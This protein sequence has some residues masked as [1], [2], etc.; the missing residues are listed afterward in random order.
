MIPGYD[1]DDGYIMVEQDLVEA[2]RLVTRHIHH[3]A[4]QKHIAAP[5]P[6]DEIVRP[7][8][9]ATK[10]Q[11]EVKG[12]SEEEEDL[13]T[14]GQLLTRRPP[15]ALVAATPI[16]RTPI[17]G[18]ENTPDQDRGTGWKTVE[19]RAGIQSTYRRESGISGEQN[20]NAGMLKEETK[21]N[22]LD[23]ET[24]EDDEDL[25]RRPKVW[26][27]LFYLHFSDL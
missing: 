14:L 10:R 6:D 2:A 7:T 16:R 13:S 17:K 27:S 21:E 9:E 22:A 20:I 4:Y 25:E 24:D 26:P 12:D 5:V 18:K 3:E 11:Q 8:I 15:A 1:N 19:A 23:E